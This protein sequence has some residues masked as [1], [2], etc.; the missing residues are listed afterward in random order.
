M[1]SV[2]KVITFAITALPLVLAIGTTDSCTLGVNA[3]GSTGATVIIQSLPGTSCPKGCG[4][5]ADTLNA[6]KGDTDP[7]EPNC[8]TVDNSDGTC[9]LTVDFTFE[10][11]AVDP[12]KEALESSINDALGVQN[13]Q[14]SSSDCS[15]LN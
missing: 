4:A 6:I 14:F 11:G 3:D 1:F 10:N 5:I 2:V 8:H 9:D 13:V 7:T 15:G 12:L